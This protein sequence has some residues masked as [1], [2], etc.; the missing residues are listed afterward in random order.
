M[1]AIAT[2]ADAA[3]QA[4]SLGNLGFSISEAIVEATKADKVKPRVRVETFRGADGDAN[5]LGVEL[6]NQLSGLLRQSSATSVQGFFYVLDR[7]SGTSSADNQPCDEGHPW[8]DILVKGRIDERLGQLSL[9]VTATRTS[10]TLPIFDRSVSLQMDPAMEAMMAKRLPSAGDSGV[11]LRPGYDPD[12]D[13]KSKD[14]KDE[15]KSENVTPP[16]C[17]DCSRAGY[18]DEAS[19]AK[20]QGTVTLRLLVS[21]DGQPLKIVL[22]DGLPCG[23]NRRAMEAVARWTLHPAR[24]SRGTPLEVWQEADITFQLY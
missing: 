8:P 14:F 7:T 6:A 24:D 19:M 1:A 10:S 11:W 18:T 3:Q 4:D 13:P 5:E 16:S 17:I 21:K 12:Q 22:V 20:I 23:M 9:R 2:R 15:P